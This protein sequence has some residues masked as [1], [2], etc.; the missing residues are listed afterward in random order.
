MGL[1]RSVTKIHHFIINTVKFLCHNI[2][3]SGP[4]PSVQHLQT[5]YTIPISSQL[6]R[7]SVASNGTDHTYVRKLE[8]IR[9]WLAALCLNPLFPAVPQNH[10]LT[11]EDLQLQT[12][13]C[14][15]TAT[16]RSVR[17]FRKTVGLRGPGRYVST[18]CSTNRTKPTRRWVRLQRALTYSEPK[19]FSLMTFD[20]GHCM[21]TN[22]K[23]HTCVYVGT[24][25]S[26]HNG[27]A[28]YNC[29]SGCVAP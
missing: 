7:S 16:R 23:Q 15:R 13:P 22:C 9:Q 24:P 20:K 21:D 28:L 25:F 4:L 2:A 18:V 5:L 11:P 17:L 6:A 3:L 27:T 1:P 19:S 29:I 10:C 8:S 12:L 26:Q 14:A